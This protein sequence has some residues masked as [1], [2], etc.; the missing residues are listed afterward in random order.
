MISLSDFQNS[1]T[2]SEPA[3]T[4]ADNQENFLVL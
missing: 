1:F 3:G 2:K 4:N